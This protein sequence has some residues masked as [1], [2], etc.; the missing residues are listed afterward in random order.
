MVLN[1][2]VVAALKHINFLGYWDEGWLLASSL[3]WPFDQ[4]MWS[5]DCAALLVDCSPVQQSMDCT[6]IDPSRKPSKPTT[7]QLY[8]MQAAGLQWSIVARSTDWCTIGR[9][10]RST[11]RSGDSANVHNIPIPAHPQR[12]HVAWSVSFPPPSLSSSAAISSASGVLRGVDFINANLI[13]S[14]SGGGSLSWHQFA[15][16][17]DHHCMV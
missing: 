16:F 8:C 2:P 1:G 15:C 11:V 14:F 5:P 13:S 7:N 3:L 4:F 6:T 10:I 17:P 12:P 9:S